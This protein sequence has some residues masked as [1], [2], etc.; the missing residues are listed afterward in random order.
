MPKTFEE[1]LAVA[2]KMMNRYDVVYS[3]LA[4]RQAS[5]YMTDELREE[6]AAAKIIWKSTPFAH[7]RRPTIN[8]VRQ[9]RASRSPSPCR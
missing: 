6:L 4:K 1:Q 7:E 5:P 2:R 8:P 3:V 9:R